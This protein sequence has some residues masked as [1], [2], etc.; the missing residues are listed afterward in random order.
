MGVR[1]Y[2]EAIAEKLLKWVPDTRKIRVLKPDQS[3]KLF[4][5]LAVDS[6]DKK[7]RLPLVALSRNPDIQLLLSTK[8]IRSF[9][10]Y[11]LLRE[12]DGTMLLNVI[13]IKVMYQLDIYTKTVE[14]G[15]ELLRNFL[16]KLINNPTLK[17]CIPYN[18][19]N[20]QHIANLRIMNNVSDTSA[21]A[22]RV[23]SGQFTRWSIQIELQDG[24]LFN[25]PI[26]QNATLA[27]I[28]VQMLQSD[29]TTSSIATLQCDTACDCSAKK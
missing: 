6:G 8:N 7:A 20:F 18:N 29:G 5:L 11:R 24:F 26:K 10:G 1:Y 17:I 27:G 9:D 25:T 12:P 16:F 23:F 19:S 2:D 21:I 15:D 14:Q 13:P 22:Q 4:Q 28:Q 3:K